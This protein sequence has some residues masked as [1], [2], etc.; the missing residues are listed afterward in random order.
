[1]GSSFASYMTVTKHMCAASILAVERIARR[2]PDAVMIQSESAELTTELR[3]EPTED[4]RLWNELRFFA[5]DL[6]HGT[7]PSAGI[8]RRALHWG[9]SR[10]EYDWFM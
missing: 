1:M 6:L 10:K 4:T 3:V 9:L 8:C 2:R 5:L 7:E